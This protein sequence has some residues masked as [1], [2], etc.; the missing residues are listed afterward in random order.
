MVPQKMRLHAEVMMLLIAVAH[1]I[2][3]PLN[4]SG[5]RSHDPDAR[6]RYGDQSGIVVGSHAHRSDPRP[7]KSVMDDGDGQKWIWWAGHV[8]A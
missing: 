3:L 4:F 6:G 8:Y 7:A 5:S 1:V 2:S